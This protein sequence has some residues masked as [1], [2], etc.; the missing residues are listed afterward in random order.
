MFIC[1]HIESTGEIPYKCST[2]GIHFSTSG[3]VKSHIRTHTGEKPLKCDKCGQCFAQTNHLTIHMRTHTGEKPVRCDLCGSRFTQISNLTS[4]NL[5][6]HGR[7]N[8]LCIS[9]ISDD[10]LRIAEVPS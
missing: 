2:C 4:P 5:R 8:G 9:E 7:S 6:T 1:A 10:S 3:E